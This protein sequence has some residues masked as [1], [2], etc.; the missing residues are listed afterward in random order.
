[1]TSHVFSE[2]ACKSRHVLVG[3]GLRR[4]GLGTSRDKKTMCLGGFGFQIS[5]FARDL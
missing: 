5:D 2:C 3:F 1:M 4:G